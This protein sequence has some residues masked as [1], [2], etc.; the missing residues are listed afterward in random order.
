MPCNDQEDMWLIRCQL[1]SW[2]SQRFGIKS[3]IE[4]RTGQSTCNQWSQISCI[5]VDSILCCSVAFMVKCIEGTNVGQSSLATN[6]RESAH[7]LSNHF[8]S[9]WRTTNFVDGFT[10]Y[11]RYLLRSSSRSRRSHEHERC[12]ISFPNEHDV[13]K[14]VCRYQ[15]KLINARPLGHQRL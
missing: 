1:V 11:R 15:C 3:W 10:A 9:Q 12:I 6:Y 5:M 2:R 8:L 7:F 14:C 4:R 13:S